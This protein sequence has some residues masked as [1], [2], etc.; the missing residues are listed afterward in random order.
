MKLK[1]TLLFFRRASD[2]STSDCV[3][4]SGEEGDAEPDLVLGEQVQRP[5]HG[6]GALPAAATAYHPHG[7]PLQRASGQGARSALLCHHHRR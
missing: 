2:S 3:H 5:H 6:E 7:L 4:A 1:F